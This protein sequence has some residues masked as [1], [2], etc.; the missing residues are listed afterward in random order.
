MKT[1]FRKL[2]I[3]LIK[4]YQILI[5]PFK[6]IQACKFR[7]TCSQYMIDAIE[8]HGVIKGITLGLRRLSQCRPGS[9]YQGYDPVPE[10]DHWHSD[11]DARIKKK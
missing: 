8:I 6:P 5:S 7:P 10:K 9:N 4:L 2:F 3:S 1:L 11:V